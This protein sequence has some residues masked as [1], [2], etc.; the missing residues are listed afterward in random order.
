MADIWYYAH[1][2]LKS[3]PLSS[4]QLKDLADADLVF[5]IDTVWKEGTARGVLATKVKNLLT[6]KPVHLILPNAQSAPDEEMTPP[7]NTGDLITSRLEAC[8]IVSAEAAAATTA[9]A[10]NG[11]E[12]APDGSTAVEAVDAPAAAAPRPQPLPTRRARATAGRGAEIVGQDGTTVKF[13]KRC[14]VCGYQDTCWHTMPI[15]NGLTRV[16]FF[17]PKCRK[18]R[19]AEVHGSVG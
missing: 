19:A 10:G 12:P 18:S 2:G 11:T 16:S 9:L 8:P 3:G 1:E 17:C 13:R 4:R 15:V 7:P 6:A 5:P 14:I